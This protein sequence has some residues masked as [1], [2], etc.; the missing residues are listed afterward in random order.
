MLRT[1]TFAAAMVCV[2]AGAAL[3]Q[4]TMDNLFGNTVTTTSADGVTV[5]WRFDPDN[6]YSATLPNGTNAS[7]SWAV[8]GHDLCVTP[9]DGSPVQCAPLAEGKTAGDTWTVTNAEGAVTTV[10]IIAGR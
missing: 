1:L 4:G 9:S 10:S 7:G 8:T 2:S 3:A 5:S 6:T